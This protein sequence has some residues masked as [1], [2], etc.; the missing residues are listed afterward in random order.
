MKKLFSIFFL[1]LSGLAFAEA[2]VFEE[3]SETKCQNEHFSPFAAKEKNLQET[4]GKPFSSGPSSSLSRFNKGFDSNCMSWTRYKVNFGM[5]KI[6][7]RFP[8]KPSVS[9]TGSVINAYAFDCG[10]GYSFTGYFPPLGNISPLAWFDEILYTISEYPLNCINHIV[11]QASSGEWILDYVAHDYVQNLIIKTRAVVTPF[12]AY[13]IQCVK[14]N[15]I[16]DDFD[17]FVDSFWIQCEC[18]G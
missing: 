18:G 8:H 2:P 11:Y 1:L 16:R 10:I 14:P 17:Y 4:K 3:A 15:G 6:F 13:T 5:E 12:N 9:Q 7:L